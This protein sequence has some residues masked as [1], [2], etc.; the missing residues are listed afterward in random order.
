MKKEISPEV[1]ERVKEL[2]SVISNKQLGDES[3][4]RRV[5]IVRELERLTGQEFLST[6]D[7]HGKIISWLMDKKSGANY[8]GR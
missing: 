5:D 4:Q 3:L 8:V 1:V 2:Y 7:F 6:S